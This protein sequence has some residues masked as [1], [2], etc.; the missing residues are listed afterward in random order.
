MSTADVW[1]HANAVAGALRAS[2]QLRG[3]QR[4]F[5]H[6]NR[7]DAWDPGETALNNFVAALGML[8]SRPLLVGIYAPILPPLPMPG[9]DYNQLMRIPDFRALMDDARMAAET[10]LGLIEHIRS[11]LPSYPDIPA[12]SLRAHA[13]AV[14][15]DGLLASGMPWPAALRLPG[16]RSGQPPQA[17]VAG[18]EADAWQQAT[19]SLIDAAERTAAWGSFGKA[20][21]SLTDDGRR[22]LLEACEEFDRRTTP[23]RLDAEAGG[24]LISRAQYARA[25]L[26]DVTTGLTDDARD[27]LDAFHQ[28][29]QLISQAGMVISDR[30][31]HT[32]PLEVP[33]DA[34]VS[35][36]RVGDSVVVNARFSADPF[37]RPGRLLIYR[38][39][40]PL[41]GVWIGTATT[42]NL[43]M[44]AGGVK[45][46]LD[47]CVLPD[48]DVVIE[49][50]GEQDAADTA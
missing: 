25:M 24:H 2:P 12:P 3:L 4:V 7:G 30:T 42:M 48:S 38:G 36:Q 29:D 28:I 14:E 21:T 6:D 15:M 10:L 8:G 20:T 33:L 17:M 11:R 40:P 35:W 46:G 45:V 43:D 32:V 39:E 22:N 34:Q 16:A 41:R 44:A 27:Y 5:D 1:T 50:T 31:I 47:A 18:V 23:D 19:S 13:P 9:A 26:V 49:L 37:L